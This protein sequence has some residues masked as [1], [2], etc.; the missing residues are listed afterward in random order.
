MAEAVLDGKEALASLVIKIR[1][2]RTLGF[3]MWLTAR[4]LDAVAFVSPVGMDAQI[5]DTAPS[6]ASEWTR[7]EGDTLEGGKIV[8]S[9][10][11][12]GYILRHHGEVV[13]REWDQEE[14]Q[15]AQV[16]P[17]KGGFVQKQGTNPEP[18][19]GFISRPAPPAPMRRNNAR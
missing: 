11:P 12:E 7:Y 6:E 4:L 16:P 19:K 13:W 17:L 15:V 14:A 10:Y 2:P 9:Q 1:W 5:I 3:R 18:G 8:L